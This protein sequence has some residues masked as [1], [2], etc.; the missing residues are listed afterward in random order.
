MNMNK[1][2]KPI[3]VT[4]S[5]RVPRSRNNRF[6]R[7]GL[8]SL[9]STMSCLHQCVMSNFIAGW[10]GLR[11]SA[12]CANLFGRERIYLTI[13]HPVNFVSQVEIAVVMS[14]GDDGF[15]L[16][17]EI[18]QQ[19]FVEELPELRIL[20]SGPFVKNVDRSILQETDNQSQ[21]LLLTRGEI[22][23]LETPFFILGF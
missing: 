15:A 17:L 8:R 9:V 16:F 13:L 10:I 2:V 22:L 14:C 20:I 5:V 3:T 4:S 7:P 6:T 23:V 1:T 11:I 21:P 12:R 18:S 19:G